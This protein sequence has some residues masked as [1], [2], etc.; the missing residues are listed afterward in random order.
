[1][2][3]Y[4]NLS[5]QYYWKDGNSNLLDSSYSCINASSSS[6]II[7]IELDKVYN[8]GNFYQSSPELI[9]GLDYWIDNE[10]HSIKTSMQCSS[11]GLQE[12]SNNLYIGGTFFPGR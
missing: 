1:M 2:E 3:G 9:T 12:L 11:Q 6:S 5:S 10:E 7:Y 4:T 8:A